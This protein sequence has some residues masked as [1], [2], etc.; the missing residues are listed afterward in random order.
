M[1][2]HVVVMPLSVWV[3]ACVAAVF[4]LLAALHANW[5]LGSTLGSG[6]AVP[7]R[8]VQV[9]GE[10]TVVLVKAFTPSRGATIA[11]ACALAAVAL[12]VALRIGILGIALPYWPL[13]AA[14]GVVALI[15]L[16]RAVGDFELVGFFKTVRA[17]RFARM[18]TLLYSPLCVA[19]GLGL[20]V[21]AYF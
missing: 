10:G 17:S 7:E 2:T 4:L 19:L 3:G 18:D 21:V 11:V 16:A 15:M 14:I 8:P 6:A 1:N 20:G 13:R 9:G 5:A 12:L